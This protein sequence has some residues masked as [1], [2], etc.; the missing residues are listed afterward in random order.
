M[1][2]AS[3]FRDAAV[4]Y[5][6]PEKVTN[7]EGR[8]F[9]GDAPLTQKNEKM[10]KSRFNVV[11][12]DDIVSAYGADSPRLYEMFMA[13][14]TSTSDRPSLHGCEPSGRHSRLSNG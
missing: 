2:V 11:N 7:R 14:F 4:K 1:I 12:P 8:Y 10:S 13:S 5:Y 3:S 9:A 6:E